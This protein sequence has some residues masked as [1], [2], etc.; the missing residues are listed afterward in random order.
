[1]LLCFGAAGCGSSLLAGKITAGG[2]PLTFLKYARKV[3]LIKKA[4]RSSNFCNRELAALQK[5]A[6]LVDTI[7]GEVINGRFTNIAHENAV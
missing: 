1:M 6:G 2:N 4:D 5:V 7:V 3:E